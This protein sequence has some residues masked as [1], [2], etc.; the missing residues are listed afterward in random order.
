[1]S[2]L[3]VNAAV[4]KF[5]AEG[6]TVTRLKSALEK[7][8]KKASQRFHHRDK[9]LSGSAN[10]KAVLNREKEKEDTFIFTR[11]ERWTE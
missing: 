2:K 10:S 7:D 8:V 1:M 3:K 5:L 9:A 6:G 4:D 11:D